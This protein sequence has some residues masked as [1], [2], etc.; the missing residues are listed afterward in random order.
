[1]GGLS[2]TIF[3]EEIDP[4]QDRIASQPDDTWNR[5][6]LR[7]MEQGKVEELVAEVPNYVRQ[8][9]VDMGF[10]H[11]A[12]LFGATAGRVGRATVH[13]YGPVYGAGAAVVEF[14]L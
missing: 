11:L 4:A 8:A 6:I 7:L 2:G 14:K 5:D 13:A 12:W 1:V 9:K 3:R 10:K